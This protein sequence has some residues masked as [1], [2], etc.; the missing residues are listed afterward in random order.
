M[1][2]YWLSLSQTADVNA[3]HALL[4]FVVLHFLIYPASNGYNSYMDRDTGPV[5]GIKNPSAPTRQL[6]IASLLLD[7]SALVLSA[8]ISAVF[9]ACIACYIAASRAYS[10]RRVRLKQFPVTGYLTVVLCQGALTFFLV[11]HGSSANKTVQVPALGMVA[12]SLLVGGFYPLT[13]I[14]QHRADKADG[15]TTLSYLL[16]YRGTFIFT[17]IVYSTAM[18]V[19]GTYFFNNGHLQTFIIIQLFLL[20]VLGYFF[21]WMHKVFRDEQEANFGRTMWMNIIGATFTNAAFIYL[22]VIKHIE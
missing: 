1:P 18:L 6:Y 7:L 17:A 11:M 8:F 5:G 21:W 14:Y 9:F 20:P 4:V 2:V 16:G 3:G 19:L 13:Q 15:V 22:F 12:A 10:Y